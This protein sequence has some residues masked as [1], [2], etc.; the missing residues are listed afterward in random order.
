MTY[1]SMAYYSIIFVFS[2]LII[3]RIIKMNSELQGDR[4]DVKHTFLI[5]SIEFIGWSL[6]TVLVGISRSAVLDK[7]FLLIIEFLRITAFVSATEL[8]A[9]I[10]DRVLSKERSIYSISAEF[11][12]IG[13]GVLAFRVACDRAATKVGLF[14]DSFVVDIN[15]SYILYVLFYVSVI[16]FLGAYTYMHYYENTNKRQ[17]YISKQ[18]AIIVGVLSASLIIE[19]LCYVW[20]ET[21]VPSVYVG[22]LISSFLF[23]NL[24]IYKRSIEYNEADYQRILAPSH[25]KPSFVCDDD[26]RI[27]FENTR[28]F[29]MRQTYKDEYLGRALTD[30]FTITDYDKE[31][32]KEPRNTQLFSVYCKYPK[33]TREMLLTV[34]HNLDKFGDIFSTE[35][36]VEYANVQDSEVVPVMASKDSSEKAVKKVLDI[37][38]SVGAINDIRTK[39]LLKQLERQKKYYDEGN[40]QLFEINIIGIEKA[41]S[42]LGLSTLGDLCGRIQTELLYGEW[43]G[44]NPLMIDLDRQYETL[45]FINF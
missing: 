19:S 39:E 38:I 2:L 43:E 15:L 25:Q 24:I 1:L 20:Y 23:R 33:E 9:D 36:E 4:E 44:L 12:Y 45:K 35:V 14:G 5:L 22:M 34:K 17:H 21:F 40:R 41:S 18:C 28:A 30:I 13:V 26:G 16:F 10:T 8:C 37:D 42:I 7:V 29:V 27:I 32:L 31:R 3:S 6:C 11:L